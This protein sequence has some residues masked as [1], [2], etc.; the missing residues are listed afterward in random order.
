MIIFDETQVDIY[1]VLSE[2]LQHQLPMEHQTYNDAYS[3]G[4]IKQIT[5]YCKGCVGKYAIFYHLEGRKEAEPKLLEITGIY[6]HFLV[7][8]YRC[9]DPEGEFRCYLNK[10]IM[11]VDLYARIARLEI[12]G[13]I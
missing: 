2:S 12:L 4:S 8:R 13:N 7:G 11:Y 3:I 9:Y 6:K 5:K 1:D 10:T